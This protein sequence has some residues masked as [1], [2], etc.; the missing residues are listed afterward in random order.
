MMLKTKMRA[1]DLEVLIIIF[2]LVMP[3]IVIFHYRRFGR[4]CYLHL[5]ARRVVYR[6]HG[7]RMFLRNFGNDVTI[8]TMSHLIGH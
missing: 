2:R 3:C 7:G 6:E 8:S 4:T 1:E 5:Q